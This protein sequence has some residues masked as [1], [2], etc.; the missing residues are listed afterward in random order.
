MPGGDAV[1]VT[2][3]RER[4]T[5]KS[6]LPDTLVEVVSNGVDI[7]Y[8]HGKDGEQKIDGRIVFT[9]AMD[10]YPNVKGVL[11]FAQ[12]C[13]PLILGHMPGATWHIVGKNPLPDVQKLAELPGV[14]VTGSVADV[15]PYFDEA[16]VAIVPFWLAAAPA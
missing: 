6:L 8:F 12:K 13:W 15:R 2:S 1:A 14:T 9:G 16:R 5:L 7:D 3:E 10:Y 4:K 11:F